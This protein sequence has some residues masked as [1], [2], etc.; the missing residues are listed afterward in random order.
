MKR[1]LLLCWTAVFLVAPSAVM[2]QA[3]TVSGTVTSVE[4]GTGL[5]GVNVVIKGTAVG[6]VTDADGRFSISAPSDATLVFTFI[7]LASQEVPINGRSTLSVSMAQ[8]IQ[9][10]SE[11]VVTAL[12][13]ERNKN[14]LPF[15]AQE[16]RGDEVTRNRQS[17]FV[18]AL[19]GKIAGVDIK[20]NNNMGGSTNVVI[21]GYS[22]ITNNNQALFVIDGIPVS[23]ANTNTAAQRGGAVGTDY[24]NA[25][26]DINPDNIASVNVL[27]GAAATALYGSRAANGVIMITTKKGRKNS[28]DVVVNSGVT[29]GTIDKTT[30]ARYQKEYG[31]GYALTFPG[32]LNLDDGVLP[33]VHYQADASFGPKYEGQM[34]YQWD[35][36]D[37]FHP[38]YRKATEWKFAENGPDTYYETSVNSNQSVLVSG[39][40]DKAIFKLGYTRTD[41][42]G[43]LP[44]SK[45]DK[46][47]FNFTASYDVTS[48]L[49]IEGSANFTQVKGLGRFGTGYS[50][51]NPN[52]A[53]RQWWATNVDIKQQREAYFRNRQ[54]ITWNWNGTAGTGPIYMDNPYWTRYE[55]YSNDTRDNFFGY[56]SA[57]YKVLDWLEV[58]GRVGTNTT[59][60]FQEERIA[61]GS[62]AL[63]RYARF[64]RTFIETNY[65]LML[66][67]NR[68]LSDD[69]LLRGLIGTNLR[70]SELNSI[71]ASTNGGLAVPRLYSL[72]NTRNPMNPPD[73]EFERVGVDGIFASATLG[74]KDLVFLDLTARQDKSTT[75]PADNNT[76]F[77]PAAGISFKF[78][79]LIEANWL[80]HAKAFVNYAEVGND[81][82]ALSVLNA[83]AK[84][85]AIG[86][87]PQFSLPS[88]RNNET[89]KPERSKNIE[90][91]IDADFFDG[92]FGFD[93]TWYRQ[94]TYDQII[95]VTLTTAT[96][97]SAKF[98]N[99]G[100]VENKG[101]EISAFVVPLK[102][103]NFSWTVNMNFTRNRNKVLS[104][105]GEGDQTV[106]NVPIQTFQGGV[107]I[108]AAVGQ[109]YG[110]IR[111][112]DFV[113]TNGQRTVNAAGYYM[114]TPSSANIIGNP[115][116]DW[117]AGINNMFKYKNVSLSFLLDMRY[118]GDIF[119]LDQFYGDG[120]G[121]YEETAGLN[122]L[123]NPK[124]SLVAEGGGVV[125]PGV[126]QDGT[127]NDIRAANHNGSGSTAYGYVANSGGGMPRAYYVYDAS[128][129]KLRELAL[130][131]SLPSSIV[132]RLGAIRN[133]DVSA[134]GRNLWIIHKNMKYSD[135]EESLSSG[136]ANGGYQSGA[137][138]A[139]RTYGFN[140]RFTF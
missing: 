101:I 46:N 34:V 123:G 102:T 60:D 5:P 121:L 139:V 110:V 63:A 95:P 79:Q 66:S 10:L 3:Q 75:L 118:G 130:T 42:K 85:T 22:S 50:G 12:G 37:P 94:N 125:L 28:L 81:A 71:R 90:A 55:N 62:A 18:N 14:E 45:L 9:Q 72:S 44:N 92:R 80:S 129:V 115:N 73:E 124:R 1:I 7:G 140:V 15:A 78:S 107:S 77:Y 119:S 91:G 108:N 104:L 122:H 4:E 2:A 97:Y 59:T 33:H 88:T 134:V 83:Y 89:L 93:F 11:V 69:F 47:M 86:N 99:S 25:A 53:F 128:F 120:S 68:Q 35:A 51:G 38:N 20:T 43:I 117:L 58:L 65:D 56:V 109:P 135:P 100:E 98:V 116:P 36:L 13:I 16:V 27:K 112:T 21:R 136:N 57:T 113:Y 26:A 126:K 132:S 96:G 105:F 137:Y 64:N 32:T 54:N 41:E 84:P 67:I 76:Y 133:I 70:R 40:T 24:G 103:N 29:W 87:V 52:Q 39:G 49:K 61:V 48:K 23:N 17:N 127:P 82:P 138:P 19:S 74:Y 106:T 131:Y 111:G 114:A 30:F 31:A 6:T 8:D